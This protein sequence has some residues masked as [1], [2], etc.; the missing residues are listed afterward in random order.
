MRPLK[1]RFL[2]LDMVTRGE[3]I[4][5]DCSSDRAIIV[6]GAVVYHVPFDSLEVLEDVTCDANGSADYG[7]SS[8]SKPPVV[9]GSA[10]STG[11]DWSS[12][13]SFKDGDKVKFPDGIVREVKVIRK[14]RRKRAPSPRGPRPNQW[15]AEKQE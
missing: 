5:V 7:R 3:G 2:Y 14:R 11:G 6:Q 10:T 4:W 15:R 12:G 8:G 9:D 13:V 1:V